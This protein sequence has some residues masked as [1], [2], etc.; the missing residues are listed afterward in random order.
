MPAGDDGAWAL[1]HNLTAYAA[2]YVAVAELLDAPLATLDQRLVTS[3]GP[4]CRFMT[5]KE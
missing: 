2:W 4:T 3:P 5:P 1:R